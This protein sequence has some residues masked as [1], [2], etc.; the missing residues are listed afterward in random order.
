[1]A[2]AHDRFVPGEPGQIVAEGPQP[3]GIAQVG[4]HAG[5]HVQ[6]DRRLLHIAGV[7]QPGQFQVT[8]RRLVRPIRRPPAPNATP[9]RS[10]V[11]PAKAAMPSGGT[12]NGSGAV[13][14]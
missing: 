5:E 4:E 12:T 8:R 11:W 10:N 13:P 9:T 3:L 2:P 7:R 6:L 14:A 1:M